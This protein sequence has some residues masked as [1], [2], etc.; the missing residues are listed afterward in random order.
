MERLKAHLGEGGLPVIAEI[1]A[2]RLRAAN[3]SIAAVRGPPPSTSELIAQR[4]L[5]QARIHR[6]GRDYAE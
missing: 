5:N 2:D 4:E 6:C 1:L 3:I